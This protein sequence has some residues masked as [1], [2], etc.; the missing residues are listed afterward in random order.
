MSVQMMKN[1][2]MG[3]CTYYTTSI[4]V[5]NENARLLICYYMLLN[6]FFLVLFCFLNLAYRM[7]YVKGSTANS[8]SLS[9][10]LM[11]HKADRVY[12]LHCFAR[13]SLSP[14]DYGLHCL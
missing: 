8:S 9:L 13:L 2:K 4:H 14:T 7:Y 10:D 1:S 3:L 5:L 6:H 11:S 12:G